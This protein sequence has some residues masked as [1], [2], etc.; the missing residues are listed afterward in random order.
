MNLEKHTALLAEDSEDNRFCSRRSI[1]QS[2]PRLRIVGEV[3]NGEQAV[4][5]LAGEGPFADRAQNPFPDLLILGLKAASQER[6][7]NPGMVANTNAAPLANGD[8]GRGWFL[9]RGRA[10][11]HR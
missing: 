8:P 5:Y 9:Y 1:R 6:A 11:T 2:A 10:A 7:G 3:R 4:A